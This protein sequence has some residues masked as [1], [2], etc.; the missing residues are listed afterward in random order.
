MKKTLL[1]LALAALAGC[2]GVEPAPPR[3]GECTYPGA[4]PQ[5]RGLNPG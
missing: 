3:G 5:C 4:S 1:V 2:A